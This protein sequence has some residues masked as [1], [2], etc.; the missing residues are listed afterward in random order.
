MLGV[1]LKP[2]KP[3]GFPGSEQVALVPSLQSAQYGRLRRLVSNF[4]SLF[5]FRLLDSTFPINAA[6]RVG[7]AYETRPDGVYV[8]IGKVGRIM[9]LGKV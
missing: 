4:V 2:V 6:I 1:S 9:L 3:A 5:S 8:S 7:G